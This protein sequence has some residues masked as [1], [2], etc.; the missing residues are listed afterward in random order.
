MTEPFILSRRQRLLLWTRYRL[1]WIMLHF[2][3]FIAMWVP[4]I[5]LTTHGIAEFYVRDSVAT[6]SVVVLLSWLCVSLMFRIAD[7]I[8]PRGA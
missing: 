6:T 3:V 4:F 1:P 5:F 2:V 7:L 8:V